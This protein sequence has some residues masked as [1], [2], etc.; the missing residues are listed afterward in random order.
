MGLWSEYVVP[1][2]V[3]RTCGLPEIH[4]LRARL[5][6]G[7]SGDVV[8]LGFGSGLN[9]RHYPSAVTR[10]RAVEPSDLA[11]RLAQDE[12]RRTDAEVVRAGRDAQVLDL[13]DASVDHVVS[14]F[15]LCTIPDVDAALGEVLR[16]LRPGGRLHFLEHGLAQDASVV[17]WQHRLTPLQRRLA[18]GCHLD[19]P[20]DALVAGAGLDLVEQERIALPGPRLTGSGYLGRAERPR[21]AA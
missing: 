5:C 17:R 2:V 20:I 8:E 15:T 12:V 6:A 4:D 3:H 10:V 19:R 11:W 1:R 21:E 13:P 18:A 9:A 7:L 14:T 16:V